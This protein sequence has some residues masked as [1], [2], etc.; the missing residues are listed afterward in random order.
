MQGEVMWSHMM[1][2]PIHHVYL[3]PSCEVMWLGPSCDLV[4]VLIYRLGYSTVKSWTAKKG[5]A[6]STTSLAM[7]ATPRSSSS[8]GVWRTSLS[9]TRSMALALQHDSRNWRRRYFNAFFWVDNISFSL[10]DAVFVC[11]LKKDSS[12]TISLFCVR[13]D[14]AVISRIIIINAAE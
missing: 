12:E 2:I 13:L 3:E 11:E 6:W 14:F 5:L 10:S 4:Y 7:S 8:R 1:S 9:V